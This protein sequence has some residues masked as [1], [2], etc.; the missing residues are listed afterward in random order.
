MAAL[1]DE[2]FN[3]LP[4][5]VQ[6]HLIAVQARIEALGQAME[7]LS[8]LGEMKVNAASPKGAVPKL[9][10]PRTYNGSRNTR[11]LKDWLYDVQQHF[12]NEPGK[13]ALDQTKIRFAASYLKGTARTWFQTIDENGSPPWGTDFKKFVEEIQRH[14]AELDPLAYWLKRWDNVKQK[15]SVNAY[16]TEFSAIASHLSLTEQ[17]KEHHFK[18]GLRPEVLDQLALL[19]KSKGFNDLVDMA[20][21]I[22]GRLFERDRSNGHH[23]ERQKPQWKSHRHAREHPVKEAEIQ[24]P[25]EYSSADEDEDRDSEMEPTVV[26]FFDQEFHLDG[27]E[28]NVDGDSSSQERESHL[29]VDEDVQ[30]LVDTLKH[31]SRRRS[32]RLQA[33][34]S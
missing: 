25:L 15:G 12:A 29:P 3:A 5:N 24:Q 10:A 34:S 17:A 14:F 26:E 33:R 20:N 28:L 1:S 2:D 30:M 7:A 18:K 27:D 22:D 4:L 11:A 31:K 16:L 19:P 8:K 21:Q 32:R 9:P 6:Q 23:H 13:F